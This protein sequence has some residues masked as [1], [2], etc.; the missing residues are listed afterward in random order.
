M[1]GPEVAQ[2]SLRCAPGPRS[3]WRI[4]PYEFERWPRA[5]DGPASAGRWGC[6]YRNSRGVG[7]CRSPLGAFLALRR[8]LRE[9]SPPPQD[10]P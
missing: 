4:G 1:T 3:R 2:E 8:R 10:G 7:N 5:E 9:P 6:C